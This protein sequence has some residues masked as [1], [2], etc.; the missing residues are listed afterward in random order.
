MGS[1]SD[2]SGAKYKRIY[3]ELREALTA[4]RYHPGD[5][6]PAEVELVQQ[7]GASRPTV[8]RAL[9]KLASEGLVRRRAG[10]G[11]F[12]SNPGEHKGYV[13]A[14][15]IPELGQTEIFE[16]ICQ[17]L[18]RA[19]LGNHHELLWGPTLQPGAPKE[20]QA[21][22]LCESYV[23]RGVSGVFFAPLELTGGKDEVNLRIA[24]ALDDARI[25]VVLLDRDIY[26]YPK[27]SHYDLVG[28]DNQRAGFTITEHF[29]VSGCKRIVF[30]ARPNSAPTVNMR[31]S[32]YRAA[33]REYLQKEAVELVEFGDPGDFFN[34]RE[35][36]SRLRPDAFVCANDF[37]A[38][39]LMTTLNAIEVG[40]PAEVRVGGIDD[41]KYASLLQVPLTTI[42][43]PCQDIGAT[44]LLAMLDR[45]AHPKAPA[46]DFLVDFQLVV[47]QSSG[48]NPRPVPDANELDQR[49]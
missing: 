23:K 7:F 37:T 17:G 31:I 21:E 13:F 1:R 16:P 9:A 49:R 18:S 24:R 14:L 28:I 6:L 10:S 4:G 38:A 47:R 2:G 11:T 19:K 39:Q 3:E 22:Q 36:L 27:R 46:R 40:V 43:Q 44:A 48:T 42:H 29:L 12:V 25:P 41:V 20:I 5:K 26:E 15:L 45:I 33:I 8:G 32:G 30:F 35:L 34:I